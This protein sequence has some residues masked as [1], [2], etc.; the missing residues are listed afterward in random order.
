MIM[1]LGA[2][3]PRESVRMTPLEKW[4]AFRRHDQAA[5]CFQIWSDLGR[6]PRTIEAYACG[7]GEY[8]LLC[9]RSGVAPV[10]ANRADM[11]VYV[12]ELTSRPHHRGPNVISMDS[13]IE[14]APTG[15]PAR[16]ATL[17]SRRREIRMPWCAPA[18]TQRPQHE[19]LFVEPDIPLAAEDAA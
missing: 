17:F 9:E 16:T 7:L 19:G 11:A 15:R 6:A 10:T 13:G 3:G 8:L 14:T 1:S 18:M 2:H 12:R 4:P 5:A